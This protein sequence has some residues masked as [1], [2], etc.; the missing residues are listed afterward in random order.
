MIFYYLPLKDGLRIA[1]VNRQHVQ[2]LTKVAYHNCYFALHCK[3]L[4]QFS[5]PHRLLA[6]KFVNHLKNMYALHNLGYNWNNLRILSLNKYFNQPFLP[7][8]S[9]EVIYFPRA[10]RFNQPLEWVDRIHLR[11]LVLG[12]RFR[13]PLDQLPNSVKVLRFSPTSR[14]NLPFNPPHQLERVIFGWFYDQSLDHLFTRNLHWLEFSAGTLYS[15][16]IT[17]EREMYVYRKGKR[18]SHFVLQLQPQQELKIFRKQIIVLNLRDITYHTY[19][20]KTSEHLVLATHPL[21]YYPLDSTTSST[22][23]GHSSVISST[24]QHHSEIPVA[25]T[26]LG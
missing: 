6:L 8:L 2:N 1:R 15:H 19:S 22:R 20:I 12:E 23:C 25:F 11:K 4:K 7:P 16:G 10:S 21:G 24:G 18:Y 13:Q 5:Y 17:T 14:Y 3:D 9:V 26:A